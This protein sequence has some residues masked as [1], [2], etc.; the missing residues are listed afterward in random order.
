M[1]ATATNCQFS[2]HSMRQLHRMKWFKPYMKFPVSYMK[3]GKSARIKEIKNGSPV[4]I[5]IA[6]RVVVQIVEDTGQKRKIKRL[7]PIHIRL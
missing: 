1:A 6:V 7:I 3:D 5:P 2:I 4:S